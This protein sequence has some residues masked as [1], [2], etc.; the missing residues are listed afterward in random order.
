M[1][2]ARKLR[3]VLARAGWTYMHTI[4]MDYLSL[5]RCASGSH[6]VLP[7]WVQ[8]SAQ[9]SNTGCNVLVPG[10]PDWT[11]NLDQS[12]NAAHTHTHT[13][14][15]G[16]AV[17]LTSPFLNHLQRETWS[18]S[19]AFAK[20]FSYPGLHPHLGLRLQSAGGKSKHSGTPPYRM[21]S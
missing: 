1:L 15:P 19:N 21:T 11:E 14:W 12:G 16:P 7:D 9:T 3:H 6:T 5:S 4:Q 17:T 20:L 8:F 10:L 2:Q 13:F 18:P